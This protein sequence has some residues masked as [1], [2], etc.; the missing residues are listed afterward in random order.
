MKKFII[1]LLILILLLLLSISVGRYALS[2]EELYSILI[3]NPPSDIAKDLFF[4]IRLPRVVTVALSGGVLALSGLVFQTVFSNPLVSPDVLGATNGCAVGAIF[5]MLFFPSFPLFSQLSAFLCGLISVIASLSLANFV[6]Q[7][8]LL[9][10]ILSGMVIGSLASAMLMILKYCADP[11]HQLPAIEYWLMGGFQNAVWD[12]V[13][14]I[15][16][17]SALPL[18]FLYLFRF[19]LKVLS[20]GDERA[21]SLGLSPLF[22]RRSAILLATILVASVISVAGMVS[23]VALIA[24]HLVRV[25]GARDITSNMGTIFCC[26]GSLL[27]LADLFA[28]TLTTAEIPVSIFTSLFGASLLMVLLLCGILE[29]REVNV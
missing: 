25:C 24:P 23:W 18:I 16:L 22:I 2:L 10:L 7:N 21:I 13:W 19:P 11:M 20:L 28:R 4:Q 3:G 15:F 17:C 14:S 9:G 12:D 5:A 8:S 29:H 27:L 1:S 6:K 26:G